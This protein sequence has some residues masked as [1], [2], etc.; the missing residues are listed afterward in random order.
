V[1]GDKCAHDDGTQCLRVLAQVP[2]SARRNPPQPPSLPFSRTSASHEHTM[3]IKHS[4]R[5][6]SAPTLC[7][8]PVSERRTSHLHRAG[9]GEHADKRE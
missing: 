6:T 7:A 1:G 9:G 4:S 8:E 3:R 2:L 5:N